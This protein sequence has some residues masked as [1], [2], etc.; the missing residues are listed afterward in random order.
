MTAKPI[1]LQDISIRPQNDTEKILLDN[2]KNL[3]LSGKKPYVSFKNGDLILS[4]RGGTE[5]VT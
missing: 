3:M 2:I 5:N 1:S 4:V